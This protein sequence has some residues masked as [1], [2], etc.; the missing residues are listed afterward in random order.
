MRL[1]LLGWLQRHL[2]A[3]FGLMGALFLAFAVA[4][5]NLAVLLKA[6]L[7]LLLEYG[8]MAAADGGLRQLSELVLSGYLALLAWLGFKCCE[9]LL[10]DRLTR[11]EA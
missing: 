5:V 6:N 1:R 3:T 9:K 4:T 11:P 7:E 10:V 8:L 2:L